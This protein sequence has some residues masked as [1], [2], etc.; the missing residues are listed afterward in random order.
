M[1]AVNNTRQII[2]GKRNKRRVKK[3][4]K[5]AKTNTALKLNRNENE[6]QVS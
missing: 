4:L 3:Y 6:E 5:K 2:F 1:S